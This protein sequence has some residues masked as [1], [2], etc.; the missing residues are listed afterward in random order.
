VQWFV[1]YV[2]KEKILNVNRRRGI[3]YFVAIGKR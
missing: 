1:N 3:A 2:A